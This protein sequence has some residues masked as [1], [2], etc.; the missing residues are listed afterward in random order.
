MNET[1]KKILLAVMIIFIVVGVVLILCGL[2]NG[3]KPKI[4]IVGVFFI[5]A[6]VVA[7]LSGI[8]HMR[9]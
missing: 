4:V 3:F 5:I 2:V 1:L 8:E 7:Y 6:G 9:K